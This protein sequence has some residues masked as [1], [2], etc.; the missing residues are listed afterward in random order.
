MPQD[1]NSAK[2]FEHVYKQYYATMFYK[3]LDW[4]LDEELA[5]DLVEELFVELWQRFDTIRMDEVAGW[6]SI[7]IRNKAIN[8]YRHRKVEQR[9][10]D[11]YLA[12]TSEIMDEDEDVH[13]ER[14]RAI[15]AVIEEQPVQRK[16]IFEQCCLKGK[17]YKEV[18]EIVGVEVTTVHKHVS[19]VYA[20]LRIKLKGKN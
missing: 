6:L 18:A 17:S 14:L 13:E 3:A 8:H 16:F 10:E 9:Y 4:T 5:K 20:A 15:E 19:K 1:T 2:D 7:T 11:E 12:V